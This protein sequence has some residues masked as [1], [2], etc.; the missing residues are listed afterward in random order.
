MAANGMC[1]HCGRIV[2]VTTGGLTYRHFDC[3]GSRQNPRCAESDARPL[4]NGKPNP[5]LARED[6]GQT[7]TQKEN[8]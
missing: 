6:R 7:H 2:R 3:P 8:D 5:H 1:P 4:W